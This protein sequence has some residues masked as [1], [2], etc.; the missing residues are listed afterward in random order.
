MKSMPVTRTAAAAL[1]TLL[2]L[3]VPCVAWFL[4]GRAEMERR[5]ERIRGEPQALARLTAQR[6]A[7]N[8]GRRLELLRER[9][10]RRPYFHYQ[11][12]FHDPRSI[13]QGLALTPSPLAEGASDPFVGAYFQLDAAGRLTSPEGDDAQRAGLESLRGAATRLLASNSANRTPQSGDSV[14]VL[15]PAAWAQNAMAAVVPGTAGR[16][17]TLPAEAAPRGEKVVIA[18]GRLRWQ[19]I[20][21]AEGPALVAAR[22]VVTPKGELLQGF[23]LDAGQIAA[24]LAGSTLAAKLRPGRTGGPDGVSQRVPLDGADWRIEVD[25]NP[26][27]PLVES[28]TA[29]VRR[30]FFRTYGAGVAVAALAGLLVVLQVR[31]AENVA[32]ERSRFAASAAHELRTPLTGLRMHAELLA[33]DLGDPARSREYARRIAAEAER[34]ARVVSNVLGSSRLERGPLSLRPERGDLEAAVRESVLR[35]APDLEARGARIEMRN[36]GSVPPLPFD[37]DAVD[38]MVRNLLDNAEKYA[39]RAADR[40]I[41]VS[42]ERRAGSAVVSVVDH[43]PGVPDALRRR[44]FEPFARAT[45]DGHPEGLGLGL[46]M[47]RGLARAHGGD[48]IY[49]RPAAGGAAFR[50][51]FPLEA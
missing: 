31:R 37:R 18:L 16:R 22:Q 5:V 35:A 14:Q 13:S 24:W 26:L 23:Q 21:S 11:K 7:R 4:A 10:S 1:L 3:A 40:S 29:D 20:A 43:G 17:P 33:D 42:V 50:V 34:L 28:R 47:V 32:A 48:A 15:E 25:A 19:T 12:L 2:L 6:L 36:D 44:L 49:E 8:L 51:T 38:Q 27:M 39:R 9:E 41:T 46:A 30:L 45:G